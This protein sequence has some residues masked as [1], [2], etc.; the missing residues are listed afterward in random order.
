[1]ALKPEA[2][3]RKHTKNPQT[4]AKNA[5]RALARVTRRIGKRLLDDAPTKHL[6]KGYSD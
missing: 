1:M 5:K 4:A 6:T 2:I 3:C